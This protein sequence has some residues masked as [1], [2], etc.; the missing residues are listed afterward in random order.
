MPEV[1]HYNKQVFRDNPFQETNLEVNLNNISVKVLIISTYMGVHKM[2]SRQVS[3]YLIKINYQINV[4][5]RC[6][7][8]NI[9]VLPKA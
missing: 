4:S 8:V 3:A 9:L 1:P 5:S 7:K 6:W 2:M